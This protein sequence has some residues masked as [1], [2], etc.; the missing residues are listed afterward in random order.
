M[1]E[2]ILNQQNNNFFLL[3]NSQFHTSMNYKEKFTP[4]VTKD[5]SYTFFS[6]EF[7]ENFHSYYG[8]KREAEIKF[9]QPTQIK[10]LANN[11]NS[12]AILDICYGLGYNTAAAL[13]AI[14]QTNPTCCVELIGLEISAEVPQQ[15]ISNNLLSLWQ[16]PIPALLS[17]LATNHQVKTNLF[18]GKLLLGDARV[19][20]QELCEQKWQAD[21]I[22][23]DP[24]SPPKCPQLWTVEFIA[25]IAQC[26]KPKGKLATYSCAAAVRNALS[27][28]GLN[29]S[30]TLGLGRKSPGTVASFENHQKLQYQY[31]KVFL[32]LS[33]Q[34][35]E[36]LKTRAA[37]PYQDI[38][39]R[40][41]AEIIRETRRKKQEVSNL[42]STSQ[43]KKRWLLSTRSWDKAT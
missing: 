18:Q 37:I 42:E 15:A 43:W 17:E 35:K 19:T 2:L 3:I 31:K 33:P 39:L 40:N 4:Q 13:E 20:I 29:F 16:Y 25:K 26:L 36:H 12:I 27:L 1:Y 9:I 21:A 5:G 34:E 7:Q 38:H 8:A 23:L 24:F 10:N 28:A 6:E 41:S 22:F 14:W 30:S 11:R 32:P